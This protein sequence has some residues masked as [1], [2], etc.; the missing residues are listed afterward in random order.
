MNLKLPN[1]PIISITPV[2]S[3]VTCNPSPTDT[4]QDFLIL[5][6]S[7]YA[8]E[9]AT[10]AVAQGYDFGGSFHGKEQ[11]A[12]AGLFYSLR[13]GE[14]NLIVTH[15]EWFHRRFMAASN[16]AKHFNLLNKADRIHLFQAVLYGNSE[17]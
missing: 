9:F 11:Y 7:Y 17:L 6:D 4:D 13:H 8:T 16:L 12:A 2:G 14:V 5:I 15:N 10:T 1:V 3:R